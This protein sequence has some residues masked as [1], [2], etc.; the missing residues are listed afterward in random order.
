MRRF[1]VKLEVEVDAK[2]T[3]D[4]LNEFWNVV[5]EDHRDL[6]VDVKEVFNIS[7]TE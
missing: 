6:I 7:G 5:D 1:M 3:A 4:A 2:S